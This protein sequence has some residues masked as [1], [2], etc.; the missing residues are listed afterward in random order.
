MHKILGGI[1][2]ALMVTAIAVPATAAAQLHP[3]IHRRD[4]FSSQHRYNVRR[5]WRPR[6]YGYV[7]PRYY[8]RWGPRYYSYGYPYYFRPYYYPQPYLGIGPFGVW[9]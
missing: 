5:N 1:A 8:G 6:F 7:G 9:W 3:G 4:E 2:A